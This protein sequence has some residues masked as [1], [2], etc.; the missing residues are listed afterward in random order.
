AYACDTIVPS[1]AGSG[2]G[3]HKILVKLATPSVLLSI[4]SAFTNNVVPSSVPLD[5][6]RPHWAPHHHPSD[7]AAAAE[8]ADLSGVS[9][10][11]A[12]IEGQSAQ[13]AAPSLAAPRFPHAVDCA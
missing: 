6:S 11:Q 13:T 1:L 2:T 3:I 9:L 12:A 7:H 4:G 8:A 5:W 10:S